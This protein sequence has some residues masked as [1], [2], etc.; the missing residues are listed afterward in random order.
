MHTKD[1]LW[2]D[3]TPPTEIT[4]V[5]PEHIYPIYKKVIGD[6]MVVKFTSIDQGEVVVKGSWPVGASV[7]W[8]NHTDKQA[9]EDWTPP[10]GWVINQKLKPFTSGCTETATVLHIILLCLLTITLMNFYTMLFISKKL[11][12]VGRWKYENC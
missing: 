12:V 8:K 2:Q 1:S 6:S 3:W 7:L 11:A 9:W 10:E 5:E 4:E